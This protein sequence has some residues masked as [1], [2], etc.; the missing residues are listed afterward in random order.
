MSICKDSGAIDELN[1][2]GQR[3]GDLNETAAPTKLYPDGPTFDHTPVQP[4]IP[5]VR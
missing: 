3:N 4:P 1:S 5:T 2:E